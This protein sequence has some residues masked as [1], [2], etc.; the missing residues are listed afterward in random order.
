MSLRVYNT[1]SRTKE[2]FVP[3]HKDSIGM[4]V[5]GPTVYGEPHLGH[6]KSYVCFDVIRRYLEYLGYK[7]KYVQNITDVGH[8]VGD[9][10][11]GED[12]IQKKSRLENLDPYEVAYQYE[13][14][15]FEN[16]DKLN[17]LRP[18]ISCRAT[19]HIIEIL[20]MVEALIE[21]GAAYV[22]D[23]GNV[24]YDVTKYP[25][26]GFLSGRQIGE[27]LSGE[28]IEIAGDK[29]NPEDFALWKKADAAHLMKWPS[30]WGEG[31]PGWHIECSTMT[32]KYLG[33]TIDIHGGGMD[34]IFPHH[35]CECAQSEIANDATFVNY[36]LHNNLVTVDGKKMGKSLGNFITLPELFEKIDPIIV[37]YYILLNHYRRPTDF[38]LEN[39]KESEAGYRKI[40]DA[41]VKARSLTEVNKEYKIADVEIAE[42]LHK[43]EEA[44]DDDFN[45][46]LAITYLLQAAKEL[47]RITKEKEPD[48]SKVKDYL[49]LFEHCARPVL[50][51]PFETEEK[52]AACSQGGDLQSQL[53]Q[54]LLDMRL[55][56]KKNKD[57]AGA[58]AIRD[59]L[60]N[61]GVVIRDTREG[62]VY[63]ME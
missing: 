14:S 1:K 55:D 22:T 17:V 32:K 19:G 53:I 20:D 27:G 24:Y 21:K 48:L 10:D 49:F 59:D 42:L 57:Y 2:T 47:N 33:D 6:A 34:N 52:S 41:V 30:P 39:M 35:E 43:F 9:S 63:E 8:L 15:Y 45:T 50:G 23:A 46:A 11:E 37:R 62:T 60:K 13:C 16:M 4:Y 25:R 31:Y 56:K 12:K 3:I 51:L 44:M 28:R 54:Y 5:C 40:C 29:R 36:F 18:S 7:V 61:M 38:N 26:Y 58:D